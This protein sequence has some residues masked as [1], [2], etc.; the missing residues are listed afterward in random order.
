[1]IS[2]LAQPIENAA[3]Q[4]VSVIGTQQLAAPSATTSPTMDQPSSIPDRKHRT[5]STTAAARTQPTTQTGATATDNG[6]PAATTAPGLQ[7]YKSPRAV[8]KTRIDMMAPQ[9]PGTQQ[10]VAKRMVQHIGLQDPTPRQQQPP[11]EDETRV[12]LHATSTS[13]STTRRQR[14][15]G[16]HHQ[17]HPDSDA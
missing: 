1:V 2:T 3:P 14:S 15:I 5:R 6:R 11:A 16:R 17:S 9:F 10:F 7:S 8:L 12:T 13:Q 4:D